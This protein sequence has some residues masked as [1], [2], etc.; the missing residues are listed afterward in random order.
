MF[1]DC[2]RFYSHYEMFNDIRN[3]L[4]KSVPIWLEYG[5]NL[6]QPINS[7]TEL[8]FA[9]QMVERDIESHM[10]IEDQEENRRMVLDQAHTKECEQALRKGKSSRKEKGCAAVAVKTVRCCPNTPPRTNTI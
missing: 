9:C 2:S 4:H 7:D 3:N 10:P 1:I 6:Y 5:P 8:R